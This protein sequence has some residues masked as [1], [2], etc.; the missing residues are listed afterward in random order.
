M[1]ESGET[2]PGF[3][4]STTTTIE[5]VLATGATSVAQL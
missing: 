3:R 1:Q 4:R 2:V 5:C